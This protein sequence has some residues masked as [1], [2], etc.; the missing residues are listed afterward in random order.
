MSIPPWIEKCRDDIIRAF[1]R[2]ESINAIC[3]V[4]DIKK[5]PSLISSNLVFDLLHRLLENWPSRSKKGR[6]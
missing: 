4:Y 2:G 6:T 5:D 3:D 1:D